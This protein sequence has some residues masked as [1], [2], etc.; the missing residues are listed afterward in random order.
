MFVVFSI[1]VSLGFVFLSLGGI[2]RLVRS[3]LL[4]IVMMRYC[5]LFVW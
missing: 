2:L 1:V 4:L 3:V 5:L